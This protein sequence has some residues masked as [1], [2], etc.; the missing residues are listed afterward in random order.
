MLF[1]LKKSKGKIFKLRKNNKIL[2]KTLMLLA[3]LLFI[4]AI[5]YRIELE[6]IFNILK[7]VIIT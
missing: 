3:E 1:L 6:V 4:I 2:E 7:E 5:R